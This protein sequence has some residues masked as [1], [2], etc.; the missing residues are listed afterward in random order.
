M[1]PSPTPHN[2]NPNVHASTDTGTSASGV[3]GAADRQN[4]ASSPQQAAAGAQQ[5]ATGSSS[6]SS[7]IVLA[8]DATLDVTHMEGACK[9]VEEMLLRS[10]LDPGM[11]PL[12]S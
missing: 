8:I 7:H 9:G 6:S 10:D 3:T 4:M 2:H 5:A 1:P 12:R 11:C